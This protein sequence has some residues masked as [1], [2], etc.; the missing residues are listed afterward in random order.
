MFEKSTKK[1][2]NI[3]RRQKIHNKSLYS[4]NK[5]YPQIAQKIAFFK[6]NKIFST[7]FQKPIAFSKKLCYNIKVVQTAP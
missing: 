7:F 4:R 5:K 6:K 2:E 1:E 3:A